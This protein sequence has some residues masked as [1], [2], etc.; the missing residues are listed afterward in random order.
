MNFL[1][2]IWN[3]FASVQLAISTLC[4]I[5]LTSIIGTL[6]PQGETSAEYVRRFG[7]KTALFFH[8]LDIPRMYSSWWF[9]GLL[10]LL[11]VNLIVCSL[12][13]FPA[14]WKLINANNLDISPPRLEKMPFSR[15]WTVST[16]LLET[17]D[18]HQALLSRS[19]GTKEKKEKDRV[20][21]LTEKG[22]WSRLG[23]YLVHASILIIFVGAI[24]GQLWGFKG[25]VMLPE[26]RETEHVF[27][28]GTSKRIPLGF[29]VRCQAF[30]IDFYDNGMVKEYRSTLTILENQKEVLTT[31]IIVNSPL[32]YKGITFYQSSYQPH[33]EFIVEI[34]EDGDKASRR[35]ALP[36]Q[37]EGVW[38]ERGL[39]FG[40]LNA[41]GAGQRAVRAKLWFKAGEAEAV[42]QW[43][44]DNQTVSL[45]IE[46]KTY[47][48]RVKQLYS[49]GL[50]VAK[51]PGV[52][53]VYGGCFF[54]LFGL[55]LA[56]FHSHQKIWISLEKNGSAATVVL[57]GTTNKNKLGFARRFQYLGEH[58]D[59]QLSPEADGKP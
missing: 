6:V 27:S 31:D 11:A 24:V 44:D 1:Q 29:T 51:D 22:R 36:F 56:F 57:A 46:G 20:L 52:W 4:C 7:E 43:L 19:G 12:D 15:H 9:H 21:L 40:L 47:T 58:L 2:N 41:E 16:A 14:A 35:F 33:Q 34:R 53:I 13:R 59:S 28:S 5:S 54:L 30:A 26:L 32:E 25:S 39:R 38:E 37:Q 18:W 3:F 55:Y 45:E 10:A 17:I 50:Q 42:N 8:I 48:V 49:T 23:V